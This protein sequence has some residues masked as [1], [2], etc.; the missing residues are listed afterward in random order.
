MQSSYTCTYLNYIFKTNNIAISHS[1]SK[2]VYKIAGQRHSKSLTCLTTS[3]NYYRNIWHTICKVLSMMLMTTFEKNI[4]IV[5]NNLLVN[6]K[7]AIHNICL[8]QKMEPIHE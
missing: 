2:V 5:L 3:V 8:R 1:I 4:A 7:I 6:I